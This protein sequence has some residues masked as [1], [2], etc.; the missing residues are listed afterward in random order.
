MYK[1]ISFFNCFDHRNINEVICISTKL[2][3]AYDAIYTI[4]ELH[5][6]GYVENYVTAKKWSDVLFIR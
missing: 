6:F 3:T 2:C 1:F 4:P 5:Q